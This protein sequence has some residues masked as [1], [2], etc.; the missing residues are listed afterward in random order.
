MKQAQWEDWS[1]VWSLGLILVLASLIL[2]FIHLFVRPSILPSIHSFN[3]FL[4]STYH[5]VRDCD[6][7]SLYFISFNLNR[8]VECNIYESFHK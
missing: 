4:L 8:M 2:L 3:K 1:R 7:C 5:Y 6:R